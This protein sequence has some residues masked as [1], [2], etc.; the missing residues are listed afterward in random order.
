MHIFITQKLQS[1]SFTLHDKARINGSF[2]L[3]LSLCLV[4]CALPCCHGDDSEKNIYIENGKI[5]LGFNKQSGALIA[6]RDLVNSHDY[7]NKTTCTGTPWEVELHQPSDVKTFNINSSSKFRFSKPDHLT[8]L[9]EW[10]QFEGFVNKQIKITASVTLDENRPLSSWKISIE[11][12]KGEQIS[13]V[14]FPLISGIKNPGEEYLA[15]PLWMGQIIKDPRNSLS[16]IQG[17]LKKF[18]WS[19]PGQLSMQCLA[20]YNPDKCCFYASCNDSLGYK[21]NFSFS[22][23]SLNDLVYQLNNY[24]AVDSAMTSYTPSYA[25]IIGSFKGDWITAAGLYREWGSKQKWCRESRFKSRLTPPW[26]E[27]TSLWVWNRGKSSNVLWPAADMKQRLGLP[28][29]VFWHWWHGCSYDDGFP[30]YFPPREGKV[31]FVSAMTSAHKKGIRAIVYMNQALWGTTT[32]SW[33]KENAVLASAKDPEG[34]TISHVFNIF[35]NKPAAYM[36]LAT[37]FWKDKYSSLCDSAVNTCEADGVYMDMACLSLLCY[38]KSHG[39]PIGGGNYWIE[40][41]GSL[42]NQIRSKIAAEKQLV[43]AGEGCGEAWLPYLDAFLTLEVS[44]ERYS[45]VSQWQ[46]IPFFQAVYH[47]YGITYGNYSS[48]IVPPYDELWP[49]EYAPKEPLKL[50]DK[51][52][53]KQFLM[54]QAR[55]FVWGLQPTIA[56]YQSFLASERKEEIGYLIS[57]AR[58]RN[59]GLKYLLYGKFLRSPEIEAPEEEFNISRLS[60]YAGKKGNTVTTLQGIFPL[61][62]S[63]TWQ[64]DDKQIG[65]ALAS[66]SDNPIR[67]VFSLNSNDYELPSSGRIYIIDADG[68]RPLTTY[69]NEIVHAD[70]IVK[71]NGVCLVEI[72]SE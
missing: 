15:V 25:A 61:I 10:K 65:I 29:N 53:N 72:T 50:L 14:V 34:K 54:E 36:C 24:P 21:K 7:L 71:P 45:G 12:L 28:V 58:T 52:F 57:L 60:I 66:I 70:F 5:M 4:I 23:D 42:T 67:V 20:L 56:N 44:R 64:S 26:L 35:T 51:S 8:L 49:D 48:L 17:G 31:S 18:E 63:G 16:Q 55:S 11:G 68:K 19:Y 37:R 40:H 1:S 69:S 9:L 62:Y 38:D 46:T 43:L 41:F 6:F 47:Q 3:I 22:A 33:I 2:H 13:R 27:N 30:E 59:N 39:H 32:E